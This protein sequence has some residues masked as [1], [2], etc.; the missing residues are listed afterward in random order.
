MFFLRSALL[1]K[2]Q[3]A[4]SSHVMVVGTY[5]IAYLVEFNFQQVTVQLAGFDGR[6]V[7]S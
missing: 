2:I 6:C 3:S 4:G 7:S 5:R 1:C